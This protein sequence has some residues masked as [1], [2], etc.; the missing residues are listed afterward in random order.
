MS[1]VISGC[2]AFIPYELAPYKTTVTTTRTEQLAQPELRLSPHS[3]GLG[4]NVRVIQTE[5][6][7]Q[8]LR[9]EE[10]WR[11]YRLENAVPTHP[12]FIGVAAVACPIGI[13]LSTFV[14]PFL[15]DPATP[16]ADKGF[17]YCVGW[18]TT[19]ELTTEVHQDERLKNR[20]VDT[21]RLLTTG[22]LE[23]RWVTPGKDPLIVEVPVSQ[24]TDGTSLRLPWLATV[25]ERNNPQIF[26]DSSGYGE[27][28]YRH[29][30]TMAISPYRL[31][32]DLLRAARSTTMWRAPKD[33]WPATI[34]L[35]LGDRQKWDSA[36]TNDTWFTA[37]TERLLERDIPV[38]ASGET[39]RRLIQVQSN[40]LSPRY[41]DQHVHPGYFEQATVLLKI[42]QT[43]SQDGVHVYAA[44]IHLHNGTILGSLDIAKPPTDDH[45][46]LPTVAALI[47]DLIQP[48]PARREGWLIQ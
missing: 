31:S 47:P 9:L 40:Q 12:S 8:D 2:T 15:H 35:S 27:I 32:P 22:Q 41:T 46:I 28:I 25:S 10:V 33:R 37:I 13:F 42:T 6:V 48:N 4:W 7:F 26:R 30:G 34:V 19:R 38:V 1:L 44:L 20:T 23:I 24:S 5:R 17:E 18:R 21:E 16:I 11:G 29:Q 36:S 3:D 39:L 45:D 43:R 14:N